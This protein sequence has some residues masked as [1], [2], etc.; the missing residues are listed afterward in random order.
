MAT[1]LPAGVAAHDIDTPSGKIHY[2]EAGEGHPVLLLHGSG[3]G[4]TGWSNFAPNIEYLAKS[5]RV[6]APDMPGWGDSDT[7][8]AGTRNHVQTALEILDGLGIDRAAFVG[9]SMGGMTST[10]FA[11]TH[12]ARI[13]HLV[14]MGPSSGSPGMFGP[15]G[16]TEGLRILQAAYRDPSIESMRKLV[17]IM[18]FDPA[19]ATEE[20]IE[21]R[22]HIASSRPDHLQNFIDG[23]GGDRSRLQLEPSKIAGIKAPALLIHGRDDRVVHFEHSLRLHSLISNSRLLLINRCGHWAQLEH[24]GEFNRMVTDFIAHN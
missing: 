6:I 24:A 5:F 7:A 10:R 19:F 23:L 14:T 21:Q 8:I 9:N 16:L 13:S 17:G 2:I 11:T 3:P 18:T 15:A 22:S 4:A 20:L 12:P 1:T